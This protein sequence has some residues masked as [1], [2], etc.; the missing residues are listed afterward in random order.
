MIFNFSSL[1][2]YIVVRAISCIGTFRLGIRRLETALLVTLFGVIAIREMSLE[3]TPQVE[4]PYITI[5]TRWAGAGPEEIETELVLPQE[6]QLNAIPGMVRMF[7]E[8]GDSFGRISMEFE[9]GTDMS[10]ALIQVTGR[11]QQVSEYPEEAREPTIWLSDNSRSPV[12]GFNLI[13][14]PPDP[15]V[16]REHQAAFPELAN[17]PADLYQ[18]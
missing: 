13:N 10:E 3:L 17:F 5:F 16:I 9:I 18:W 4:R 2:R 6:Q 7:S 11:L 12:I 14:R 15:D 8:S 1:E